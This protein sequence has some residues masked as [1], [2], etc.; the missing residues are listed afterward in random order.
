MT[1]Y[2]F[3]TL[4]HSLRPIPIPKYDFHLASTRIG[5][6]SV[7]VATKCRFHIKLVANDGK[8]D[9]SLLCDVAMGGCV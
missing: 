4:S 2:F 8:Y 9:G 6:C 7:L 5:I 1:H 3:L